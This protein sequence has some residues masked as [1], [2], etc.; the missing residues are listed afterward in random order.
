MAAVSGQRFGD[1]VFISRSLRM[2]FGPTKYT[3][4][5]ERGSRLEL[6]F[7]SIFQMVNLIPSARQESARSIV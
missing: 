5:V 1:L 3:N 4:H 6:T 2:T 7:L